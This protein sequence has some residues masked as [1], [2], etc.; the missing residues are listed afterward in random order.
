FIMS[1][2]F[3]N[4]SSM[5]EL[6]LA[7]AQHG[8]DA[9]LVLKGAYQTDSYANP[10]AVLNLTIVGGYVI[11]ASHRD[12]LFIVQVGL[13]DVRDGFLYPSH[14]SEG[15]GSIVR[16]T[17]I[18]EE[19]DAVEQAKKKAIDAFG[20]ELIRRVRHLVGSPGIP[21]SSERITWPGAARTNAPR[22][23]LPR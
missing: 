18:I 1:G 9:L 19:K 7:A 4:G 22:I 15:E 21:A 6:R 10:A 12:T 17:F 2:M 13:V 3:T 20:P 8:A 23:G 5:K 14:E 16:P 11:P